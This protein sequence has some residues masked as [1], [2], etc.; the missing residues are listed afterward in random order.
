VKTK[1]YAESGVD[2]FKEE[3]AIR[4]IISHFTSNRKGIGKFLGGITL[5]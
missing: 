1:T 3:L 2:I 5:V 4:E